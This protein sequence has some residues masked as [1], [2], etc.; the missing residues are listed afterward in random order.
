[1]GTESYQCLDRL[2]F[3]LSANLILDTVENDQNNLIIF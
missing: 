2:N 3:Q 1:M